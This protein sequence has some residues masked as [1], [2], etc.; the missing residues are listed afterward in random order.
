MMAVVVVMVG[1]WGRFSWYA[2]PS[3]CFGGVDLVTLDP[4]HRQKLAV[5]PY[6]AAENDGLVCGFCVSEPVVS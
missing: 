2:M 6:T 5:Q 3:G 4:L 1:W